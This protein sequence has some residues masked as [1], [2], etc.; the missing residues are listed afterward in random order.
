M[1]TMTRPMQMLTSGLAYGFG[2]L[3]G[4]I[5]SFFLFNRVP[6][7]W[8]LYGNPVLRLLFGVLLAFFIAGLGGLLGGVVGGWT[9]PTIGQGKGRWGYVWRS[10]ITFGVGYGLLLFPIILIVSLL[11][12]YDI[13]S[14][15][16]FVF[17]LIFG[18]VGLI[19]GLIV[20]SSLGLWTAG[21]RFPPITRWSAAGFGLGGAVLGATIW[22]F[23]FN[24]FDGDVDTGP[25]GWLLF[26]L[27]L[28]GALGGASLG[29]A[30]H[31]M[32][33]DADELLSPTRALT[34]S[35]WRNRW[36]IA[37]IVLLL[38]GVFLRPI[39]AAVADLLTPIDSGLQPVLALETTGA[40]WL[41]GT[42]LTAVPTLSQPAIAANGSG[43]LVLAWVY[44]DKIGRAHV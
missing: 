16:V 14:T 11:A 18:I 2:L 25:Y 42:A 32:A 5:M 37:V 33:A 27:L 19:F 15:P 24:V 30:Y 12:F 10:G 29:L 6:A 4:N 7:N 40:H 28:F 38:L 23:V 31:R 20:G 35:G 43:R 39:L 44:E 13:S 8:F 34:W 9:L 26:G 1:K 17:N 21:R 36:L 41:N 22:R 3:L